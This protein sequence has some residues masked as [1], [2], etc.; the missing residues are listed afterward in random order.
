MILEAFARENVSKNASKN[1]LLVGIVIE[2]YILK[3]G[4]LNTEVSNILSFSIFLHLHI[5]IIFI[6]V[7]YF[8][9]SFLNT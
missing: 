5:F 2:R 6:R 8:Y 9:D 4:T 7:L 3:L 1:V